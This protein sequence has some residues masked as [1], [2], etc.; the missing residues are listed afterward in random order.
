MAINNAV[1]TGGASGIGAA[2]ARRLATAGSRIVIADIEAE[3]AQRVAAQ[4][5]DAGGDAIAMAVDQADEASISALA[6]ASFA[7]LGTIGAVFANAGVGAGGAI[8]KASQRNIDWVLSVNLLG[9]LWLARHFVPRMEAQD[10]PSHFIITGSEH[11]LG[12]PPRGGQASV[13]TMSKHAVLGLAETLRRD[14]AGTPVQ[15]SII[16]PALVSTD[17]WNPLRTRH[18]RFGGPRTVAEIP[19]A[20]GGLSSDEAAR[21]ILDGLAAGEF[22]IFT[23][24][25]DLA[26]VHGARSDEISSALARF[27]KR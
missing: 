16:C 25:D 19:T 18:E 22:Y 26:E 3:R 23:H 20:M 2:L 7:H 17:I 13:Y 8:H 15:V 21:H 27:A 6:D 10:E 24:H 5:R 11:S 12:L 9:P 1:I 4:I 14:L